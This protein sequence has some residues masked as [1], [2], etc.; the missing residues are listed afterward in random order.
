[1]ASARGATSGDDRAPADHADDNVYRCDDLAFLEDGGHRTLNSREEWLIAKSRHSH[2][3]R[4]GGNPMCHVAPRSRAVRLVL[5][6]IFCSELP[7]NILS[8][9][10][11][12][13]SGIIKL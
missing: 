2:R 6:Q 4:M 12:K 8:E 7:L 13:R 3:R 11:R 10:S 5:T 9:T 1:M